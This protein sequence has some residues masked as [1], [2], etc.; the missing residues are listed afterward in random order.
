MSGG[1]VTEERVAELKKAAAERVEAIAG[2]LIGISDW[3][4]EHPE[5]GHQEREAVARLTA[6]LEQHGATIERQ[7]AGMET[8]F[9]ASFDGPVNEPTVAILAE[10]DALPEVGHGCGHNIIATAAIGAGIALGA[11]AD[12]LP[13]R[14]I[15]LGCPAEESAVPDAG[16]KI[17]LV[18]QG[19]FDDV[20]AAI[21]IHPGTEDYVPFDSTLVA[22]GLSF[23]FFGKPAHAAAAPHEGINA[24]DAIIQ[25][26][27]AVGLLRQQLR[28]DVRIHGII[29]HGGGAPNVI[30]PY[31]AARFRVRA[32]DPVYAREVVDKVVRCA[33]AGAV[34]TGARL[35]WRQYIKPYQNMITNHVVGDTISRNMV[36]LGGGGARVSREGAGST[37]FG[38]V[39]HVVPAAQ[40]TLRICGEECGWHSKEVA[41]ST[42]TPEGHAAIL[43]GAKIMAMTAIDLLCR[44]EDLR[45]A[46]EEHDQT[47]G[48]VRDR[49]AAVPTIGD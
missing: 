43:R 47:A 49:L 34:A 29:T 32:S 40:A 28:P 44:P 42:I 3:M 39:S 37:D 27:N 45:A 22:Y 15:V 26:F 46:S 7:T 12:Q 10:Y 35:E 5:L 19:Y 31:T 4:Y 14:V 33:E 9:R 24:L 1:Y 41:A 2:E 20:D 30:P 38:N 17:P 8:S 13:G 18:E 16:G 23:E 21:M 11:L 25:M 48:P 6:A 36:Q